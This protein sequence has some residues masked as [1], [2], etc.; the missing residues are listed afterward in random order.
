MAKKQKSA[1]KID[2]QRTDEDYVVRKM[3]EKKERE[4]KTKKAKDIN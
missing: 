3:R 4:E 1:C 2:A